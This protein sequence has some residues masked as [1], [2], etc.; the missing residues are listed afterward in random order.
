MTAEFALDGAAAPPMLNGELV[1]DAPWQGRAFGIARG[2]AERGVY[3]WD[4][5]RDRLIAEIGAFDRHAEAV[6]R[7]GGAAP[8]FHYYDHFLRALE[9]LLVERRI[10]AGSELTGRVHAFEARPH[11]HDH[12]HGDHGHERQAH[13]HDHDHGPLRDRDDHDQR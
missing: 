4:D 3:A 5:F 12:G 11:G 1:F 9:T 13:S 2:M 10:L 8:P 6:V 7:R